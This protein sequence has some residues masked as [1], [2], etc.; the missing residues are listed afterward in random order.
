MKARESQCS[1]SERK[2]IEVEMEM[3]LLLKVF[4]AICMI[5]L[6]SSKHLT[7]RALARAGT[8]NAEAEVWSSA[9]SIRRDSGNSVMMTSARAQTQCTVPLMVEDQCYERFWKLKYKVFE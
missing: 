5:T 8:G 1:A 7:T 4:E 2:V 6:L 3:R 9:E